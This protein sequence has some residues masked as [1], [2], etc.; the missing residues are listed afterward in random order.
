[1][2]FRAFNLHVVDIIVD[3]TRQDSHNCVCAHV[4]R[5][6]G[7]WLQEFT[8]NLRTATDN[9]TRPRLFNQNS[10][11]SHFLMY[12]SDL[13]SNALQILDL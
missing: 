1:M 12:F 9:E 6:T 7:T 8:V 4:H 3:F 2:S 11:L 13:V 5:D 10:I